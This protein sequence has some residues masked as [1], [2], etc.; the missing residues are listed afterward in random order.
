MGAL[1]SV[2]HQPTRP[3]LARGDTA[4]PARDEAEGSIAR[5]FEREDRRHRCAAHEQ[6]A[7]ICWEA[8][9]RA[10]PRQNLPLNVQVR[11]IA[12]ATVRVHRRSDQFGQ[13]AT[14]VARAVHPPEEA[15]VR[16]AG[17]IRQQVL[18]ALGD[19]IMRQPVLRQRLKQFGLHIRRDRRP[20]PALL[21]G[22][23]LVEGRVEQLVCF[24]TQHC[25][26]SWV[27]R[28]WRL[29]LLGASLA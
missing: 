19:G 12:A 5:G 6:P 3:L 4:L 10:A 16:V 1:R 23:H 13:H 20:D 2:P 29:V 7:A 27:E 15:R 14:R 26:I 17:A 28:R 8:H 24:R 21:G 9:H 18:Q 11:V 22:F 25:P